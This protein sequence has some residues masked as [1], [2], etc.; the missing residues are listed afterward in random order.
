MTGILKDD[1]AVFDCTADKLSGTYVK[2]TPGAQKVKLEWRGEPVTLTGADAGNYALPETLPTVK[3]VITEVFV[4]EE[5]IS[6]GGGSFR[7]EIE[8]GIT[9]VP[10][11]LKNDDRWNTILKINN[12][13]KKELSAIKKSIKDEN[14]VV[15]DVKLM[16]KDGE[17]WTEATAENF[18]KDGLT[19]TIPYPKGTERKNHNFIAAHL[20]TVSMNG[21]EAGEVERIKA[22]AIT[23][24]DD[25]IQFVLHGL[26]PIAVGWEKTEDEEKPDTE[27]PKSSDSDTGSK[28]S[29]DSKSK[30]PKT[31]DNNKVPIYMILM[32]VSAVTAESIRKYR[33]DI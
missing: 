31:G 21:H 10:E 7:L 29:S 11:S 6:E 20:F 18:P 14:K 9:E 23:K 5:I 22:S 2:V 13:M 26:S 8:T 17:S 12:E 3:G 25:G 30:T 19:V 32:L 16:V 4:S 27:A 28:K 15:Y 1:D 24:T 33:Q